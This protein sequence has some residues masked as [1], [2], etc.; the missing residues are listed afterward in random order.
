MHPSS[1]SK[2]EAFAKTLPPIKTTIGDVGA[3]DVGNGNYRKLFEWHEWTYV[4]MD[5]V[6]GPNVDRTVGDP[7]NFHKIK[8]NEFDVVIS[9]Q[10]LEHVERPWKFVP[11][12]VRILKPGGTLCVIAPH[13]WPYHEHPIDC[14]RIFPHGMSVLFKDAGLM[15]MQT[16]M[17][18]TDTVGIG[19]KV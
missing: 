8:S 1:Y 4:G 2:M 3:F 6:E 16:Y 10:T 5:L 18:D 9:G 17:A 11:E 7:E 13:T 12:L 14:W 19:R 15:I